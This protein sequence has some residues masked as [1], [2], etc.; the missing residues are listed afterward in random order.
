MKQINVFLVLSFLALDGLAQ[1]SIE[2][3]H[4]R[5]LSITE[6]KEKI[7]IDGL[8]D[9]SIWNNVEPQTNFVQ[10]EPRPGQNANFRTEVKGIYNNKYLYFGIV[11]YDSIGRNNFKVPDLKRDF[12]FPDHD[13]IGITFD[14]FNDE[15]N[16]VTFFVNPFGAQRD[17]LSFDD[18]YF[19]ADWNGLWR[20]KTSRT[21]A[22]WIAEFE[23]P[24]KTLRYK[25][26]GDEPPHFGINFQRVSR[27]TNEKSAWSVYPRAVGFNRM[28]YAGVLTG[29]VPPEPT[30]NIQLNPYALVS[31]TSGTDTE[32]KAGG[33]LKWAVTPNLVVDATVNT[34]FA[35][36]DV[37]Q[38]VNNLT[39]FSVLFPERRQFFLENASLF[40]AG[41]SGG[42]GSVS[43]NVSLIPFFSRRIGLD[44]NDRPIPIDYGGRAV[45]RSDKRNFG[46]MFVQQAGLDSTAGQ[47]YWV[48]RYSE[49]IGK[50]GRIG[51]IFTANSAASKNGSPAYFDHTV[52]VDGFFRLD[53]KNILNTMVSFTKNHLE[54]KSGY[55][56][57]LQ[58]RYIGNRANAWLTSTWI[59]DDYRPE[60][61]FV[62]RKNIFANIAGIEGNLRGNWLPFPQKIRDYAPGIS[63]EF[64]HEAGTG[65][66]LEQKIALAPLSCNFLDGAKATF[67]YSYNYQNIKERF[68]PLGIDIAMGK[69]AY[70]RY[71]LTYSGDASRKFSYGA[72]YGIGGYFNGNLNSL[73]VNVV[74]SPYPYVSLGAGVDHNEFGK[75]GITQDDTSAT[76]YTANTRLALN[77]QLQL[78]FLYQRNSLDKSDIYNARLSWEYMPLSF[79][80]LVFN[81]RE[82]GLFE[83]ITEQN[84]I[85]KVSFLKQF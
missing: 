17:Y 41:I 66:I 23:I 22:Y 85:V 6:T 39:R 28:E 84:S 74:Y 29:F 56:G 33:E 32:F 70:G 40:G 72:S 67:L 25:L 54:A 62:S 21:N 49:N 52:A 1:N 69:Y 5:T 12:N 14:G 80:Y 60:S 79:V 63:T 51:T 16:S 58:Y 75:V 36:A 83:A 30:T 71:D 19:D 55:A 13:L 68:R 81:S 42:S 26:D 38:L 11:C 78:T 3:S 47:N 9:E 59:T 2:N 65:H 50:Y 31:N 8:L 20:V 61:G 15:R 45:Y 34:D 37:D 43:G 48:G 76:L 35:Q 64:Y 57:Y 18:T 82:Y 27:S 46:A 73:N 4:K 7:T 10:I 44:G 24:W 77:P 53:E